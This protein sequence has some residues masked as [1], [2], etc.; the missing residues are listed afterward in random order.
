MSSAKLN[1]LLLLALLLPSCLAAPTSTLPPADAGPPAPTAAAQPPNNPTTFSPTATATATLT[2]TPTLVPTATATATPDPYGAYTIA[3]LASR[4]YGGGELQ[5][6]E[7]LGVGETFTRYLIAY[8]SDGLSI[9]GFMNV[10]LGDGPFPV[11][12]ALHGYIDPAVYSTLD[13]TTRYADSLAGAGYLV[14]H[15]NLRGYAPS[16]DSPSEANL[17]RVGFAID[18]LNLIALVKAGGGQPG[19]LELAN[20]EAIGLWGHSMGGGI[21]TRVLTVSPDVKAAVLYGAMSGD[22]QKNFERI[23]NVFSN[24]ARGFAELDTPTEAF[25]NI[26]PIY[27]LDRVT[28]SV[29]IHHGEADDVVPLE[30]SLDLCDRLAA[31]GRSVEC[32]T[33]PGQPHTFFGDGDALFMERAIEFF[34]KELKEP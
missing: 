4:N 17:F 31:L 15:P 14:L 9:Y 8:P 29:S 3:H 16:D 23:Y 10:P 28:A 2:A 26:S 12:I 33:Y 22:D 6:V 19:P 5:I 1:L 11:V 24:R 32:F 25:A 34:D 13:Y 7:T 18:V 30:W 27:F 21:S 20:S